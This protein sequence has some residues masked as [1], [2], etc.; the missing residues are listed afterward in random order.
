M[1]VLP[2]LLFGLLGAQQVLDGFD[3]ADTAA[4]RQAWVAGEG[5]PPVEVRAEDGRAVLGLAAPFAAKTDL[6][7]SVID[8]KVNLDLSAPGEFT[9]EL[10]SEA[11][12]GAGQIS[13]YFR[14]G[15]G[16]YAAGGGL[17]K[18]G[19]Q[20]LSF[21]KKAFRVEGTPAGWGKIDGIRIAVWR[22]DG[23]DTVLKLRRLAAVTHE[24]AIIVPNAA[25]RQGNGEQR[26]ARDTA[27]LVAGML[28]EL[29]L[30][31]DTIDESSLARDGLG[32]RRVAVLAYNPQ[33]SGDAAAALERFV[34]SG[35]KVLACY[36]L[37]PRLGETLGFGKAV[38]V[39][40]ERPGQFAEIRFEGTDVAGLPKSVTQA[41]WNITA[42]EPAGHNAR[43]IARWFD[44]AGKPTGR[45]AAL[46]SD[47][48]AFLSH[49]IL[50]DDR[51]GKKQMLAA[52]LGRFSPP[53]WR[54]MAE[55]ASKRSEQIGH[56]QGLAELAE[57][58]NR[59][60][61]AAAAEQFRTAGEARSAA[62]KQVAQQAY[63]QAIAALCKDRELSAEAYLRAQPSPPREGRAMWNHSGTGAYPGGWD[64][65][66]KQLS[67]NGFNMVLPNMLWGGLAHYA[68]DVLPRSSTFQQYGDQIEQCVAAGKKHGLEVHVWKVNYNLS[69][70]PKDFVP[71]LRNEHRLQVTVKGEPQ[72]W[73]CPSHPA[74]RKLELESMLEV[75]R[76]YAVTGLHFDYI[77][78]PN[79]E[80]CYCDGC[81]QRFEEA[82]GRKVADWPQ[83]C[84]SGP[85]K[86][87]YHD[88]RCRQIT[89]LVEAVHREAKRLRP[90]IKISAAVFGGYP[91]CRE[92]VGQDWPEWVKAGYLDFICPMDYTESDLYFRNLVSS[93]TKLVDGRIP[94]YPGIGAT[95]SSSGLSAD[96]V[97]GQIHLARSLG[98]AGFTIFNL[99]RGTIQAIVPGVGLGAGAKPAIP[100]HR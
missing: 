7:R 66:A 32:N 42:A 18:K 44:D 16:W 9:L 25:G 75:A 31:C 10:A 65:T 40:Q 53:L 70:A 23:I 54:E 49:I 89:A 96:R 83:D 81:R 90:E 64:R 57:F 39:A 97:A 15:S 26:T 76:K 79:R 55:A 60:G 34:N 21:P 2:L 68:S 63:P 6:R 35:G 1:P 84:Y 24:V 50:R 78:Y 51:E 59:S 61:N 98:A 48:G 28:V 27:A 19:W 13:L 82:T 62:K 38:H 5:T 58:I 43:V 72:D 93:Q 29:G 86:D 30:G 80:C 74:N 22:G 11:P 52:L 85:R 100:P 45:P 87:E 71:K 67:Q 8:R 47:R 41:S 17:S 4:A 92:S 77:R 12:A 46:L 94:I 56:C 95:A 14:S 88:W 33:L 3:Y 20:T 91:S 73:L 99:D 69:T 36:T 37:P